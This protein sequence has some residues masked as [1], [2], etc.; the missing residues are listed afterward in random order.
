[1]SRSLAG[2]AH[3]HRRYR[4]AGTGNAVHAL[5]GQLQ[6]IDGQL[7]ASRGVIARLRE[8]IE[9]LKEEASKSTATKRNLTDNIE[10]RQHKSEASRIENE[11]ADLDVEGAKKAKRRFDED[12]ER[13]RREQ[14]DLASKVP[15]FLRRIER[16]LKRSSACSTRR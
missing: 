6:D 5:E 2:L 13:A 10:L 9:A 14:A 12:Y 16:L 11:I 7:A 3:T 4:N 1:M 8:S 15:S